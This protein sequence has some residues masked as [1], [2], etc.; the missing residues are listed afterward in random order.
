MEGLHVEPRHDACN[1][2]REGICGIWLVA[3]QV[4]NDLTSGV[5]AMHLHCD[6]DQAILGEAW[7]KGE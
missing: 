4:T 1:A 5:L 7:V 3:A 6:P 2:R